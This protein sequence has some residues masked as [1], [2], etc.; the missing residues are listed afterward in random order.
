MREG[1]VTQSLVTCFRGNEPSTS[2]LQAGLTLLTFYDRGR[3]VRRVSLGEGVPDL[4]K[5][6]RTAS[7]YEWGHCVGFDG[8]RTYSVETVDRGAIRFDVATGQL[9]K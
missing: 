8:P 3:L 7:H 2:R 4:A 5:L 1:S 6:R 9:T